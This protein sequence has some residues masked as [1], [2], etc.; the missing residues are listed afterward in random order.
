[1]CLA[2]HALVTVDELVS[3]CL[4]VPNA[5]AH[6]DVPRVFV[7]I[8]MGARACDRHIPN[9]PTQT[10]RH[11]RDKMAAVAVSLVTNPNSLATLLV[12]NT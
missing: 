10:Y 2:P 9:V 11:I 6:R 7:C 5:P 3:T 1:M 8:G 4:H 12:V